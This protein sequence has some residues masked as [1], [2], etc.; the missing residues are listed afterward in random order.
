M[1]YAPRRERPDAAPRRTDPADRAAATQLPREPDHARRQDRAFRLV[2][3]VPRAHHGR[4]AEPTGEAATVASGS[5][6][7]AGARTTIPVAYGGVRFALDSR[8]ASSAVPVRV[9][10]CHLDQPEDKP[11]GVAPAH[12]AFL[13]G[14][15]AAT[16][17][18]C[19]VPD[20]ARAGLYVFSTAEYRRELASAGG[21][22][23]ALEKVL[24]ARSLPAARGAQLPFVPFVDAS[25]AVATRASFIDFRGGSG[26]LV[27]AELS[28][29]PDTLGRE[30]VLL[31]QG[32]S[33]DRSRYLLGIFPVRSRVPVVPFDVDPRAPQAGQ[34]AFEPYRA[35]VERALA[36]AGDERFSPRPSWLRAMLATLQI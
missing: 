6:A 20:M 18:G 4:G 33:R 36:A 16:N 19:S 21:A 8:I 2:R 9:E 35:G 23:K 5:A 22:L 31:F 30:L 34:A 3:L 1:F 10:A 11:D 17:P 15:G 12:V 13:L 29:E 32:L 28:I 7:G 27:L 24:A 14:G 25:F 26:V